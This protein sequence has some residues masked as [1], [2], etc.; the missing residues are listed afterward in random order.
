MISNPVRNLRCF[1]CKRIRGD[2][3][4]PSCSTVDNYPGQGNIY[5]KGYEHG[6]TSNFNFL[7]EASAAYMA[8]FR[9]GALQA[10]T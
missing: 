4:H 2:A 6:R 9:R 10:L 1:G 7:V 3:H 5:W 8:G